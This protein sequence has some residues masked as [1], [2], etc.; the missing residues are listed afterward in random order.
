MT[1]CRSCAGCTTAATAEAQRD[2]AAWLKLAEHL[3]SLCDRVEANIEQTLSFYRLPRPPQ[4][5]EVDQHAGT[6]ERGDQRRTQLVRIFPN[7]ESCLRL[8]RALA[9]EMHEG[10]LEASRYLNM[11]ILKEHKKEQLR[12][13]DQAA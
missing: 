13:L 6:P 10:W 4:T 7:P 5:H 11:D 9:V 8:V 12:Q 2:L 1:A 3:P